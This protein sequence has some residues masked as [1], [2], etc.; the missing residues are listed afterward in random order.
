MGKCL[1]CAQAMGS[2]ASRVTPPSAPRFRTSFE[3]RADA[4]SRFWSLRDQNAY[5]PSEGGGEE[6][7]F[8]IRIF[9]ETYRIDRQAPDRARVFAFG[10]FGFGKFREFAK[11]CKT[12]VATRQ[13]AKKISPHE[14]GAQIHTRMGPRPILMSLM[15]IAI[16]FSIRE[17]P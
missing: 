8:Q 11:P 3:K 1:R 4:D 9:P 5:S 7:G 17:Q 15:T 13:R 2:G 14:H 6:D 16:L 10:R 12:R